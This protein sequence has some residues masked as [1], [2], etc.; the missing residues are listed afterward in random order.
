MF[1][2]LLFIFGEVAFSKYFFVPLPFSFCMES[3]SYVFSFRMVVFY[4][5]STGWIFDIS[6]LCENSINQSRRDEVHCCHYDEGDLQT[7]DVKA[8][9]LQQALETDI[10]YL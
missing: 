6:L 3:T 10:H 4:V 7:L 5:V 9:K 2:F 1:F 8:S